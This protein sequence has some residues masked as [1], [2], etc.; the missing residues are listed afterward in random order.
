MNHAQQIRFF[1]ED[2]AAVDPLT[3]AD[4]VESINLQLE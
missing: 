2:A 1:L 4:L 3:L